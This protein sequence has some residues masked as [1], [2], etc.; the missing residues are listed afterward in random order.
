M[1]VPGLTPTGYVAPSVQ[2]EI[3]D[4]NAL[5][6]ANVNPSLDLDPDQPLGQLI[7]IFAEKYGELAELGATVYNALNP[8]AAEGPL[9]ANIA[10]ISGTRPQVA[11]YSVVTVQMVLNAGVSVANGA[12][13]AVA[14]QPAN[15]WYLTATVTNSTS[16]QGTFNGLFR[17]AIP[18]SFVANPGTL[19]VIN[20][21]TIGWVSGSNGLAAV[22]GQTSDTDT[23]LRLRRQAELGGEGGSNT[24]AIRAAVLEVPGVLTCYVFENDGLTVNALGLPPKSFRVVL[25][26]GPSPLA[27]NQLIANAIWAQKPSGVQAFGATVQ[28]IVDAGGNLQWVG[29]DRVSQVPLYITCTTTPSTLTSNGTAAVKAALAAYGLAN[30]GIGTEA[31]ALALRASA[32]VPGVNIDV[33]TFAFDVVP[34][35]TNTGNLFATGLQI[36]TISTTNITVN[37]M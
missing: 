17:S 23:S 11:T 33:P 27:S 28:S 19:T 37:G 22:A 5:V 29:F 18:G 21:P 26:D 32:I 25:W 14:G 4:V 15:T 2:E 16:S 12:V 31:V 36:F 10:A 20:T 9:L 6:L 34:F 30:L 1:T 8:D 3:A 35:P 13:M 24:D 7:G